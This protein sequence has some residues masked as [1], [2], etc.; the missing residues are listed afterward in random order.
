MLYYDFW[1]YEFLADRMNDGTASLVDYID[2]VV[3]G[4][5]LILVEYRGNIYNIVL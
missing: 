1:L 2:D 5:D 3:E 4:Y